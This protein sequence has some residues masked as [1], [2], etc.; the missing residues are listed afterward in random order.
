MCKPGRDW[1]CLQRNEIVILMKS[2]D[3]MHSIFISI[4]FLLEIDEQSTINQNLG[5]SLFKFL[6]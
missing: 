3:I 2:D 4:I 5:T 6:Y 1:T